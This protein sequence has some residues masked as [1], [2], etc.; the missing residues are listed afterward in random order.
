MNWNQINL[1]QISNL[2]SMIYCNS[3]LKGG[4]VLKYLDK[5]LKVS[6]PIYES[7]RVLYQACSVILNSFRKQFYI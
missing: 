5:F 1:Y 7:S 4:N 6:C 3:S 2:S